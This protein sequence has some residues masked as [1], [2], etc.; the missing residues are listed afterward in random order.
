MSCQRVMKG[1]TRGS[2]SMIVS[3]APLIESCHAVPPSVHPLHVRSLPAIVSFSP[4]SDI[5]CAAG[6]GKVHSLT[7]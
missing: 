3:C 2:S 1:T 7:H 4:H 5:L 6:P